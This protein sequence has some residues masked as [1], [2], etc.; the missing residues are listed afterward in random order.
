[1]EQDFSNYLSVFTWRYGSPE[2]RK[3]FSE[4]ENRKKWRK[5][6]LAL[7]KAQ[8]KAGLIDEKQLKKLEDNINNID[9]EAAHKI[10]REIKHDLMAELRVF[11]EQSGEAGGKLHLGATSMDIEDNAE[12]LKL[13]EGIKFIKRGIGA[14]LLAYRKQI[15]KYKNLQ[16]IAQTHLQTAEPSTLGYRF[17][18]Y[19]QDLILDLELLESV[20]KMVKG[21]G[22]K[23][24]VGTSAAYEKLLKGKMNASEMEKIA[25]QELKLAA[26][27]ATTQT[28]PRK[29][30]FLVL[31]ALASVAA[32]LH[33]FAFD[34]RILQSPFIYELAEPFGDKQVGSSAMPFKRNPIKAERV[35]SLA[36][37]VSALPQIMWSNAANSLL[38]RTLDDSA[39][40]R[41]VIP[42]AFLGIDEALRITV[43]LIEGMVVNEMQIKRNLEKFAP[44]A[45]TEVLLMELARKGADRQKMHELIREMSMMAWRAVQEGKENP[46]RRLAMDNKQLSKFLT[47]SEIRDAFN[48]RSHIGNA[49]DKCER[50]DKLIDER[51]RHEAS[52]L[53]KATEY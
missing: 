29:I 22:F 25:M 53:R 3:L 9:I 40:R 18:I 28:Y 34:L 39:N 46:L 37:F 5:V 13:L 38:E 24:A 11:A 52:V 30:D 48:T 31:S 1:M 10:E 42:E 35:C 15:K 19:A 49:I 23:G 16:I 47:E 44:F 27:E 21:K 2:M 8:G 43:S 36:R 51:I 33:K 41:I 7:A 20:E 32:S 45:M 26:F 12:A 14:C 6:W 17:T 50:F 4:V